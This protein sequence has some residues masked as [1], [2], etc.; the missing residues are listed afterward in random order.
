[1]SDVER[2]VTEAS[3]RVQSFV[4]SLREQGLHVGMGK[5]P[6]CVTCG[7]VWP[8]AGSRDEARDGDD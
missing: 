1:M 5:P 6:T 7:G 4:E 2:F 8:C 3:D